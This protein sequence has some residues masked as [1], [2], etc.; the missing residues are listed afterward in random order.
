M[1]FFLSLI[2][3]LIILRYNA[4]LGIIG[5]FILVFIFIKSTAKLQ[6]TALTK[7]N[8]AI[9]QDYFTKTYHQQTAPK[10][11][12][13]QENSEIGINIKLNEEIDKNQQPTKQTEESLEEKAKKLKDKEIGFLES[14]LA[15]IASTIF[16]YWIG[17][18]IINWILTWLISE[19]AIKRTAVLGVTILDTAAFIG[20]TLWIISNL[21]FIIRGLTISVKRKE[22]GKTD[23]EFY[24]S[25]QPIKPII[26]S[27]L[28]KDLD[29][30][31]KKQ[32]SKIQIRAKTITKTEKIILTATSVITFIE[33]IIIF[34]Y[35]NRT[36]TITD[37]LAMII[38]IIIDI[39]TSIINPGRPLLDWVF[40][41]ISI[42]LFLAAPL[43]LLLIS[44][45]IIILTKYRTTRIE[46][47]I[48]DD[49]IR[50]KIWPGL[51]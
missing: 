12:K 49:I 45:Y 4:F 39:L 23:N 1:K 43:G 15:S 21:L 20:W 8:K 31:L 10:N 24:Q 36:K 18:S 46:K 9:E 13:I 25:Y 37:I 51:D 48:K 41:F 34:I 35:T 44:Y 50:E 22:K 19:A 47:I 5:V 11:D 28:N 38:S 7:N 26:Y 27:N 17:S 40:D 32:T 3:V 33:I 14:I 6:Q 42:A 2:L 16:M 29:K 30:I